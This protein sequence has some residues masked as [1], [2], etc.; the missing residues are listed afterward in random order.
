MVSHKV[1]CLRSM[2]LVIMISFSGV[3][4]KAQFTLDGEIRPRFEYR[5]GYKNVFK[6]TDTNAAFT[7]QRTRLNIGYKSEGYN[8][9]ISIQ[10]ILIWGSQPQLI[11]TLNKI[12]GNGS[13]FSLHEAWAETILSDKWKIKFGRQE[14]IL[15]DHRIFGNVGWT[16]QARSHDAVIF[17]YSDNGFDGHFAVA[18]NQD[19]ARLT[20]TDAYRGSYKAFQYFWFNKRFSDALNVSL[21]FLN[22]G[23]E[24]KVLDRDIANIGSLDSISYKDNYSQTIGTH[25]TYKKNKLSMLFNV[26]FQSGKEGNRDKIYYDNQNR[27]FDRGVQALDLRLDVGYNITE[28]FSGTLGY[29]YLSG[30]SQT[31]PEGTKKTNRAFN[32]F[33]GTNHKFNGYM[34]YFYV[35]NYI[36]SVG[37][38][39]LYFKLKYNPGKYWVGMDVHFFSSAENVWDGFRYNQ[40]ITNSNPNELTVIQS[41]KYTDYIMDDYLGTEVDFTLGF[42]LSKGVGLKAGYSVMADTETLAYLK[43]TQNASGQG[44]FDQ[45]NTWGWMMITI[46][47]K[48]IESE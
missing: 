20:G 27:A 12:N 25:I 6:P 28:Q 36:G 21:L 24:Q 34:D 3:V 15:N 22:N 8:F 48:F 33:Y 47:P 14:I 1:F 10:D 19:Q 2:Y 31:D 4:L 11:N 18:Y 37:L 29:E 45:S 17:K 32:P 40:A 44:Q 42:Q 9:K 35:G 13:Y 7:E 43:G 23:K 26:Y 16:S 41:N 5:H 39:D 46:K 30:N 38:N